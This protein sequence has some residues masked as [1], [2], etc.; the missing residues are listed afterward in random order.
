MRRDLL[1]R[2]RRAEAC[3]TIDVDEVLHEVN[4]RRQVTLGDS[5]RSF[6]LGKVFDRCAPVRSTREPLQLRRAF[7]VALVPVVCVRVRV[8]IA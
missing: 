2:C 1:D 4:Q 7:R 3:K 5:N 6:G 8:Q